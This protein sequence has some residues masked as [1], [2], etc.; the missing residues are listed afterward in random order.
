MTL[1]WSDARSLRQVEYAEPALRLPFKGPAGGLACA[2]DAQLN[3]RDANLALLRR[4]DALG[5]AAGRFVRVDG[6]RVLSL[7]G[8]AS[9]GLV[10]GVETSLG[11]TW[12]AG[13]VIVAAGAWSA[14]VMASLWRGQGGT[15]VVLPGRPR[16]G[17]LLVIPAPVGMPPLQ[18]GVM[19]S[20]YTAHYTEENG[21]DSEREP[22]VFT[23][24][25]GGL[26]EILVGSSREFVG[27]DVTPDQ[28][29]VE[30]ILA[31]AQLFMPGLRDVQPED[32]GTRVGLRP[33]TPGAAPLIGPIPGVDGLLLA[34]GHEGSGLTLAP[35]T[36][37]VLKC[38]LVGEDPP[39]DPNGFLPGVRLAPHT[40]T[41]IE[42]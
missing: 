42:R 37:E 6:E 13:T 31:R 30:E 19:E 26:G 36:A 41:E 35:G 28:T 27:F 1:R 21:T 17:H 10:T 25:R 11:R 14:E 38:M 20:E 4:C 22:V 5:A 34:T 15:T 29:V 8:S 16:R 3:A 7:V 39:F 32:V 33:W 23:A 40:A 18:R 9:R 2:T 24:T 12:H